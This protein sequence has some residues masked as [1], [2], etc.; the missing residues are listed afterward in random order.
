MTGISKK[1]ARSPTW[2][3]RSLP[4]WGTRTMHFQEWMD[5][6]RWRRKRDRSTA[7]KAEMHNVWWKYNWFQKTE[8]KVRGEEMRSMARAGGRSQIMKPAACWAKEFA[9]YPETEPLPKDFQLK[10]VINRFTCF[11][12]NIS[13]YLLNDEWNVND[14][15]E[16][17]RTENRQ[18]S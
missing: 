12:K 5:I 8:K 3:C 1:R 18:T 16:M 6:S 2:E 15:L 14:E 10:H 11:R 13:K 7:W 9:V 17:D 4:E